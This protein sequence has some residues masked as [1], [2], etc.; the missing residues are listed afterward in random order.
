MSG[1]TMRAWVTKA[2][3]VLLACCFPWVSAVSGGTTLC[4]GSD[5]R[6]DFGSDGEL[7]CA[8]V[9][10]LVTAGHSGAAPCVECLDA[11]GCAH[12]PGKSLLQ[13]P[14]PGVAQ[15]RV[16]SG[17]SPPYALAMAQA[18]SGT[19]SVAVLPPAHIL[20]GWHGMRLRLA[21]LSTVLLRR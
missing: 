14:P 8:G 18:D 2:A 19:P 1:A 16:S 11:E 20:D 4:F 3:S 21:A 7:A 9:G 6:V 13:R 15:K 12:V 17:P 10:N 5:G